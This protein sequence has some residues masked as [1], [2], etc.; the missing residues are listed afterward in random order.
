MLKPQTISFQGGAARY[1]NVND[2]VPAVERTNDGSTKGSTE[3]HSTLSIPSLLTDWDD[4][5]G[6]Q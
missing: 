3:E 2:V 4:I 5:T 6:R 1:T